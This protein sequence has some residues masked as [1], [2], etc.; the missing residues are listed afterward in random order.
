[1]HIWWILFRHLVI[2]TSFETCLVFMAT[3]TKHSEI[4][5][6]RKGTKQIKTCKHCPR[7]SKG[8]KTNYNFGFSISNTSKYNISIGAIIFSH[9]QSSFIAYEHIY[10][11][12]GCCIWHVVV[13][14]SQCDFLLTVQSMLIG[15]NYF[16]KRLWVLF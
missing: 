11:N 8:S 2:I 10:N 12:H 5:C 14:K 9:S 3:I 4:G 1:M 15:A 13:F 6:I 16:V 7:T